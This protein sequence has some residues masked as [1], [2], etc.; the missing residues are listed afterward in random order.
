MNYVL[1]GF[2]GSGKTTVG[3]QLASRTGLHLIDA[4]QEI[5]RQQGEKI[6]EIFAK[7]GEDFFRGLETKLLRQYA[8]TVSELPGMIL[9]AGGGMP[10]KEENRILMRRIGKIIYLRAEADTLERRLKGDSSRPLLQEGDLR[11]RIETLMSQRHAVYQTAADL[12]IDTDQLTPGQ[13][14]EK[15][16]QQDPEIKTS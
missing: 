13:I 16:I 9:S 7:R 3:K 12:C 8:D 14:A 2:M 6:S 15:I 1:I 4:D 5:E 11:G 10:M